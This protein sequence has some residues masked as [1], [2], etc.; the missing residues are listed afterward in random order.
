MFPRLDFKHY[1][2]GLQ[3]IIQTMNYWIGHLISLILMLEYWI[4]A[5]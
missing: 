2:S 3:Q 5:Y 4:M 1:E